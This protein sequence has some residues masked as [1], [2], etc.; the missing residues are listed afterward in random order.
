VSAEV[1]TVESF[2][3]IEVRRLLAV[4]WRAELPIALVMQV[5]RERGD[6]MTTRDVFLLAAQNGDPL[7]AWIEA[8]TEDIP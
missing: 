8:L 2:E 5:S 6:E 3:A 4:L 1:R 7:A